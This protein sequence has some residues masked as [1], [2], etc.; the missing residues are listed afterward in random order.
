AF[1]GPVDPYQDVAL[2]ACRGPLPPPLA[3]GNSDVVREGD[4]VAVTGYPVVDKFL[5]LGYAPLSST[6][7]G[8]ISA[9]Q[10]RMTAGGTVEEL[11]TDAAINHG[12]SGGPVYSTRDGSVLGLASAILPHEHGIGFATPVNAL[13]RLLGW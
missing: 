4:E 10:R 11:Q 8:A 1:P 5:N 13:R 3:L 2:L 6:N 12:N 7:R 9:R